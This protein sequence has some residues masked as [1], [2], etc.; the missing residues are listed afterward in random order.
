M[1]C[2]KC[3]KNL[4]D[5]VRFCDACGAPVGVDA[6]QPQAPV[7][8][9]PAPKPQNPIVANFVKVFMGFFTK[10][11][12][13]TAVNAGKSNTL[14]WLL[15]AA[16]S[17]VAY[18]LALAAN[19]GQLL[20]DILGAASEYM[21]PYL[22]NFG[23]WLLYGLLIGIGTYFLMSAAMYLTVKVAYKKTVSF[24]SACNLV[25][26]A[27]LPLA[28]VWVANILLGFVW[29]PLVLILSVAALIAAVILLYMGLQT[30]ADEGQPAPCIAYVVA[31]A[32]VVAVVVILVAV[33]GQ[34]AV[35]EAVGSLMGG[36]MDMAGDMLGGLEDLF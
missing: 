19:V 24:N 1:F 16:V 22:Y 12:V 2:S 15:V 17:V 29:F 9:A 27:S 14:E 18:A 36:A 5:G 3:G 10:D 4:A 35:E 31:W 11:P 33:I 30:Y 20:S 25:A 32:A 34:A 13:G 21:L 28:C 7:Y 8:Y 23:E 26:A 6:A